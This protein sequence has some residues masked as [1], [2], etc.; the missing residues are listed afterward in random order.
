M[1]TLGTGV[2]GGFV[3]NGK[4]WHGIMGMAGEIGHMTVISEGHPCGCGNHGCLEQY[5]S[6]TAIHR[7]ASEAADEGRSACLAAERRSDPELT[8]QSVY[9][10]ARA[11]DVTAIGIFKLAGTAL[12]I[13]LANLINAFNLP[14]YIIGGGVAHAW[15]QF[16]PAMFQ[17][18]RERSIVFRAGEEEKHG[19]STKVSPALLQDRAGLLGAAR[20][21]MIMCGTKCR[22]ALAG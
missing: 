11:G 16:S 7:M 3:V 5:A 22:Q 10:C 2:G 19:R 14:M 8:A 4:P 9:A 12:G 13:A 17:E 18:L 15:E 20:L 1:I 21:P 6:A